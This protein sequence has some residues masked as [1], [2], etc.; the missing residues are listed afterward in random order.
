MNEIKLAPI[1]LFVYNRPWHTQQTVEAL[2][3]NDL[4]NE[5]ELYIYSDAPKNKQATENVTKVRQYIRMIEEFKYRIVHCYLN[6]NQYIRI[7]ESWLK[8]LWD[9]CTHEIPY[10]QHRLL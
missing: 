10:Y 9:S 3:K 1:V 2:Q 4:A 6:S 5:S 8:Y 7:I